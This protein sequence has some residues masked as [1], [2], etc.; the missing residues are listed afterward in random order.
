MPSELEALRIAE[1]TNI[2]YRQ[3]WTGVILTI[4][5]GI[6]FTFWVY[7]HMMYDL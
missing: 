6:F 3:V 7:I 5:F 1:R 2:G 4:V